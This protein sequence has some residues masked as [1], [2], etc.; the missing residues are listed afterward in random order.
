MEC[1]HCDVTSLL[2][3]AAE[4]VEDNHLRA[5]I[6]MC[7]SCRLPVFVDW[8]SSSG[9]A[10]YPTSKPPEIDKTIRPTVALDY[11]EAL[12]CFTV[13]AP[14]ATVAMCRRAL[15]VSVIELGAKKD[16][17]L[18]EQIDDLYGQGKITKDL[19]D[20]AHQIRLT[21]NLGAHPDKDGLKDVTMK[22]AAEILSFLDAYFKYVYILPAQVKKH[23]ERK[24][25]KKES[26]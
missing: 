2:F 8:D 3:P 5:T 18:I 15:Q 10:V 7:P 25:D 4:W 12:V 26:K 22:D 11:K 20:W 6:Y 9:I 21:G 17:K 19:K 16:A 1:P 13:K 23:K 24:S 14:R